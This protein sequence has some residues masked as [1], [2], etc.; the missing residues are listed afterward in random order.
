MSGG[1]KV[2]KVYGSSDSTSHLSIRRV[3]R[4]CIEEL[5]FDVNCFAYRKN[6][7]I[8]CMTGRQIKSQMLV[9]IGREKE[10]KILINGKK[11]TP[12]PL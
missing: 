3:S 11:G 8:R 9:R 7:I 5:E 10:K 1:K 12:L 2:W 6:N 4:T